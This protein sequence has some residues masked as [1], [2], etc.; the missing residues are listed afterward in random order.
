MKRVLAVHD[1]SGVGKCSLTVALPIISALGTECSVLPTAVL[2][3]HTGGLSGYTFRDLTEDARAM[4]AHWRALGVRFDALYTGYICSETQLEAV[5]EIAETLRADGALVVIDPVMADGGRLYSRLPAGFPDKMRG[6]CAAADIIT[7]NI[8]EASLLTG[9]EYAGEDVSEAQAEDTLFALRDVTRGAAVLTGVR[10]GDKL[11]AG[12]LGRESARAEF[13]F[14]PAERGTFP[15]AGD[16]FAS[17]LTG[18]VLRGRSIESAVAD[19]VGFT[20]ESVKRTA[21]AGSDPRFGLDFE[22]GLAALG[23]RIN[24]IQDA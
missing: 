19:A 15:G 23:R 5:R 1:I 13:R 21:A 4:F 11:G 18:A 10:R 6:L 9:R 16:V 14:A 20:A 22:S 24:D 2:S 12:V 3:T 17:V 7:P 8:T